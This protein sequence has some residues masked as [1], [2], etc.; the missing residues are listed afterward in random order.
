MEL[1][2]TRWMEVWTEN[3]AKQILEGDT[4]FEVSAVCAD[5]YAAENDF[6][7]ARRVEPIYFL[8]NHFRRQAAALSA[9][10]RNYAI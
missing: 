8:Y 1:T 2:R 5:I 10:E 9:N 4:R 3:A 7:N 6:T